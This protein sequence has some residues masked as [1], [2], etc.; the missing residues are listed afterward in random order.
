[1]DGRV[2]ARV[3]ISCGQQKDTDEARIAEKIGDLLYRMGFDPYIAVQ[4]QTLRGIKENIFRR[5]EESEYLIFVD[6]KRDR[7]CRIKGVDIEDA[8]EHRGSLFSNQE[9][10]IA[11]YL[12]IECM[13]FQ[14]Q[15][16]RKLD[17]VLRFIQA[18]CVPFTDRS[19]LP[20]Q[21]AEKAQEKIA[22]QT[23]NPHWRN[24][25]RLERDSLEYEDVY[26][27]RNQGRLWRWYHM[28]VR[29]L[30]WRKLARNCVVYLENYINQQTGAINTP[31]FVEFKWKGIVTPAVT[32]P[33]KQCRYLDALRVSHHKPNEVNLAIN[34]FIVDYTGFQRSYKIVG[35]GV[36]ELTYVLFSEDFFPSRQKLLLSIG[37]D[38]NDIHVDMTRT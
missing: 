35:P 5:L 28:R 4:E 13:A 14:E 1:M 16:V 10:A 33:P 22:N 8:G 3:F 11:T 9:L 32:I 17:G 20:Q 31:E 26:D 34:P 12:D 15:G 2:H 29:N 18:N 36:Y 23:W 30:H 38:L 19:S 27:S 21:I 25:L 7:L 37:N 6:F 24:E